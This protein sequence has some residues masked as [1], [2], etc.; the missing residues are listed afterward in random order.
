MRISFSVVWLFSH[1]SLISALM[2]SEFVEFVGVKFV[3][4][5]SVVLEPKDEI[6]DKFEVEAVNVVADAK[7][8]CV[9]EFV[10]VALT[11]AP[12]VVVDDNNVDG[13]FFVVV[14]DVN[15]D[16]VVIVVDDV[17][18]DVVVAFLLSLFSMLALL[19]AP[20]FD[21]AV[22][23]VVSFAWFVKVVL[24][25]FEFEE[26][27][28]AAVLLQ[29]SIPVIAAFVLLDEEGVDAIIVVVSLDAETFDD[30][31]FVLLARFVVVAV[32]S[33]SILSS[34]SSIKKGKTLQFKFKF[35]FFYVR[36]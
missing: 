8:L 28:A 20:T 27:E 30:V 4:C 18:I 25:W 24:L 6:P 9:V 5:W 33:T 21:V 3:D 1:S 29:L 36:F 2:P 17:F 12:V 23:I 19:L 16:V 31:V 34:L 7:L 15:D 35:V 26:A 22:T 10:L 14:V 11:A 13:S 32:L